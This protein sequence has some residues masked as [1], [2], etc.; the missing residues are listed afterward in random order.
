[1][2]VAA[3]Q[4][5]SLALDLSGQV[6]YSHGQSDKGMLGRGREVI[7]KLCHEPKPVKF[8]AVETSTPRVRHTFRDIS[9]GESSS[10]AITIDHKVFSWGFGESQATGHAGHVD[11]WWPREL[12]IDGLDEILQVTGGAQHTVVLG[13]R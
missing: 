3:G 8:P 5:F 2:K 11:V 4:N 1:V 9:A 7:G 13:H 6:V 10:F 12:K